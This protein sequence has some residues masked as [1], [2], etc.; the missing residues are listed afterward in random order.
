M[1]KIRGT[2]CETTEA[3]R[4]RFDGKSLRWKKSG[5]RTWLLVGCPRGQFKRGRCTVGMRVHKFLRHAEGGRCRVGKVVR[6]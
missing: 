5:R 1:P 3:P 4:A 6:K 2:F